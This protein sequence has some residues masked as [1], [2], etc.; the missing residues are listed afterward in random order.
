MP[1][2]SRGPVSRSGAQDPAVWEI[3]MCLSGN[4]HNIS[5]AAGSLSKLEDDHS[6]KKTTMKTICMTLMMI[7]RHCPPR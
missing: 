4:L 6:N 2:C 5:L 1:A 3:Q 7:Q